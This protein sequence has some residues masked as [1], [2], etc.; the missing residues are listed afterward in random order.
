[1]GWYFDFAAPLIDASE[2]RIAGECYMQAT[3]YRVDLEGVLS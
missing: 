1:M 3:Y 2:S